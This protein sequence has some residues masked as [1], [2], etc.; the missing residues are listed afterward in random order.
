MNEIIRIGVAFIQIP[1]V[2][3]RKLG[4]QE[5]DGSANFFD[6]RRFVFGH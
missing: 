6:V 2:F 3:L 1:P 4:T 5:P